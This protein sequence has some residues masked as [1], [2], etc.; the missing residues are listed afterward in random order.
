MSARSVSTGNTQPPAAFWPRL[1]LL[2]L[3]L[4]APLCLE[5][6]TLGAQ[7][8]DLFHAAFFDSC[9]NR[10]YQIHWQNQRQYTHDLR[11][12]FIISTHS[13]VLVEIWIAD[14]VTVRFSRVIPSACP[15]VKGRRLRSSGAAIK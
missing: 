5:L 9:T 10:A 11:D 7:R 3:F 15:A 8:L 2:V 14:G 13:F 1:A 12:D 6:T 4:A